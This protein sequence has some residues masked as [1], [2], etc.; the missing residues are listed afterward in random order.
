MNAIIERFEIYT[1][2]N[3]LNVDAANKAIQECVRAGY[4]T[5]TQLV[6]AYNE[7]MRQI[8]VKSNNM[9]FEGFK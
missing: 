9:K 5:A 3:N 2:K 1:I 8:A 4:V 7:A 6:L